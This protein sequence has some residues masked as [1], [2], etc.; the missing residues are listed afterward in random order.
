MCPTIE[1]GGW[2][3]NRNRYGLDDFSALNY[4]PFLIKCHFSDD[5]KDKVLEKIK[6]LKYPL[7]ILKDDQLLYINDGQIKFIG[8]SEEV[9]LQ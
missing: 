6:S 9:I 4:V 5:K 1:V 8:N 2:K 7:K 3:L